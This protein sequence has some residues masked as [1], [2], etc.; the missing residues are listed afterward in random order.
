MEIEDFVYNPTSETVLGVK[1]GKLAEA[2][3]L[4]REAFSSDNLIE[5]TTEEGCILKVTKDNLV[6]TKR[7][8]LKAEDLVEGDEV[9]CI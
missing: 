7:G 2:K 6:K 9:S 5:I 3:V 8:W 1:S 4:A